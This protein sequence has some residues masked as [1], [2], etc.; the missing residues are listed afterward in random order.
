LITTGEAK[1]VIP[2]LR[3]FA[4]GLMP[5]RSLWYARLAFERMVEDEIEIMLNKDANARFRCIERRAK[6]EFDQNYWS[7]PGRG[8]PQRAPDLAVAIGNG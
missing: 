3:R 8:L 7:R 6:K 1:N 4:D 2:E 5:G